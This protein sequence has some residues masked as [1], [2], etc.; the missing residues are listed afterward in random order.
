VNG[1][2][3][4]FRYGTDILYSFAQNGV[5]SPPE[6]L[7]ALDSNGFRGDLIF[8][9]NQ[10]NADGNNGLNFTFEA[11]VTRGKTLPAPTDCTLNFMRR[12]NEQWSLPKRYG[13]G[14]YSYLATAKDGKIYAIF[15]D[16]D[17]NAREDNTNNVFFSVS[18][19]KGKTWST[20]K[21]VSFS[22][23]Y[24]AYSP[25][26]FV[27]GLP[28]ETQRLHAIWLKD[29]DAKDLDPPN[30]VWYS[31]SDN[32][33]ESWSTPD[34]LSRGIVSNFV[35]NL[36]GVKDE[37]NNIHIIYVVAPEPLGSPSKLF[38]QT[39]RNGGRWSAPVELRSEGVGLNIDAD[40]TVDKTGQVHIAWVDRRLS[41]RGVYYITGSIPTSSISESPINKP[42]S[43]E[44]FQNYPNPFNPSTV[45]SYQLPMSSE[46]KL[47]V[48]DVLGRELQ[49]LVN[50]RQAAGRYD[51]PFNA[52]S[53]SSGVYFY[54][55]SVSS[56][57]SLA[58]AFAE[59]K[60]MILM[61]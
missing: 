38:Y 44:L 26:I 15:I 52:S 59:T 30:A 60:K 43:F 57:G 50:T 36:T 41:P 8:T 10:L 46:V 53:L 25:R 21:L 1:R 5:W 24:A 45:I 20:S 11:S 7:F 29:Y 35:L 6:R 2:S 37:N 34:T 22:G 14:L 12:E 42:Q 9:L 49:T 32:D 39:W 51:V 33:G 31:F 47:V 27:T 56:R 17:A 18:K 13:N 4:L 58:G 28:E 40:I 55:L 16:I 23:N 19:D 3:S 61:K 48:F 54:R